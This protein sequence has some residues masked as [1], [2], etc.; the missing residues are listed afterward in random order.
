MYDM[1][2]DLYDIRVEMYD[3]RVDL[4]DMFLNYSGYLILLQLLKRIVTND[5]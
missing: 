5:Y 2:V 4:Y 3:M 1:R